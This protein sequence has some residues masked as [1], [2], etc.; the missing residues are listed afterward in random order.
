MHRLRMHK[1]A[2]FGLGIALATFAVGVTGADAQSCYKGR[3]CR[4]APHPAYSFVPPPPGLI[5]PNPVYGYRPPRGYFGYGASRVGYDYQPMGY[6]RGQPWY[7]GASY[8][9]PARA[10]YGSYPGHGNRRVR[11]DDD[12]YAPPPYH[13]YR[14][15]GGWAQNR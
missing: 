5:P 8:Y 11:L 4:C 1:G 9:G 13:R 7:K 14:H 12:D 10:E 15:A 6:G 2:V 3:A